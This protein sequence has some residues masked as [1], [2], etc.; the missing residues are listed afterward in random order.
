MRRTSFLIIAFATL[1]SESLSSEAIAQTVRAYVNVDSLAVGERMHLTVAVDQVAPPRAAITFP[2]PPPDTLG[3]FLRFGDLLIL[4]I[5]RRGS[6]GGEDGLASD[7]IVYEATTFALDTARAAPMPVLTTSGSD[8]LVLATDAFLIPVR[9]VVPA[10]AEDIMDLMPIAEF[11]QPAW[12]WLLFLAALLAAMAA[13]IF[14]Y[15]RSPQ[16]TLLQRASTQPS[17]PPDEEAYERLDLL[18][19]R[20]IETEADREQF[21]VDLSDI[22]RTYLWRRTSVHALEMTT[23][24]LVE[25]VVRM[26]AAGEM[27]G[28]VS[29]LIAD[30]LEVCDLAK[31]AE[32]FPA[33]AGCVEEAS[34]TREVIDR[35]EY[36]YAP[37]PDEIVGEDLD[38]TDI[39]NNNTDDVNDRSDDVTSDTEM[40][41]DPAA[42]PV[43]NESSPK[44]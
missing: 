35:V 29:R 28:G 31:F 16:Q 17:L 27:S 14:W 26:E 8:T 36:Y 13:F 40:G 19:S 3:S 41:N 33:A 43:E 9:S 39:Q 24:E 32:V 21:C 1:A 10:D 11:R 42:P 12:P 20:P 5:L 4:D 15:R 7:S 2:T 38:S 30:V 44:E 37:I 34:R 18:E 25:R 6:T 22:L 23:S